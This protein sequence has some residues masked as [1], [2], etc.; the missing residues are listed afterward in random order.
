MLEVVKPMPGVRAIFEQVF[1]RL[2][3][4]DMKERKNSRGWNYVEELARQMLDPKKAAQ[5]IAKASARGCLPGIQASVERAVA[6]NAPKLALLATAER[7]KT[8]G[9]SL[10][11]AKGEPVF[12]RDLPHRLHRPYWTEENPGNP[13]HDEHVY[14]PLNRNGA[15]LGE[16][17]GWCG[18]D[19]NYNPAHAWHFRRDPAEIGVL[20]K[21]DRCAAEWPYRRN[22]L[23][24]TDDLYGV[25]DNAFLG[26]YRERLRRVLA[27][28]VPGMGG[29]RL[30]PEW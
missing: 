29:L 21:D 20:I 30:E 3:N 2:L 1:E 24:V 6:L 17:A 18:G 16:E 13:R 14:M 27:E 7:C 10:R 5:L 25:A 22:C 12:F 15:P 23:Y 8:W 4:G 26:V 28:A 9:G 19:Y 11:P